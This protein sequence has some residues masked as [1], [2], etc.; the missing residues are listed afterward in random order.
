MSDE[1]FE[2]RSNVLGTPKTGVSS[3]LD[4]LAAY[5]NSLTSVGKSP[6]R[7]PDQTLTNDA[8][9]G[10]N[11][12]NSL[13]CADCHSGPAFTDS[14]TLIRHNVGTLT[15][16]SGQRL[17]TQLDGLDTPTLKGLWKSAPYLHDGSAE[18][19]RDVLTTRNPGDQH[20]NTSNLS[21]TQLNQLIA[22]LNQIDDLESA[23]PELRNPTVS[24]LSP[25]NRSIEVPLESNLVLKFNEFIQ[26]GTG[27]ITLKNLTDGSQTI[28]N[29]NDSSQV[30][31]AGAILTINPSA[32]LLH[33]KNYAVQISPTAIKDMTGNNYAGMI[34]DSTW[35]FTSAIEIPLITG[36]SIKS[37]DL[38]INPNMSPSNAIDG[39]GL[40]GDTPALEGS[41]GTHWSEQWW[42]NS[43]TG[44]ITIDLG[45]A[46]DLRTI[47]IWNYN[48]GAAI[49][50]GTR[51]AEIWVSPDDNEN[52]LVKLVTDGSGLHD[53][54]T[55]DFLLP[56]GTGLSDY[57]GFDLDLIGITNATLLKTAR[58]F[59]IKGISTWGLPNNG[60][61]Q[62]QFGGFP[63][64]GET[65]NAYE[66]W[67]SIMGLTPGTNDG[68]T[69]NADGGNSNNLLEFAFGGNPL[70]SNDDSKLTH[71]SSF[72]SDRDGNNE[73]VLTLLVRAGGT[74]NYNGPPA[75][76]TIDGIIYTI[77]GSAG[78]PTDKTI[79]I[80]EGDVPTNPA[81]PPAPAGYEY[82]SF[83]LQGS[84]DNGLQRGFFQGK[85]E[86]AQ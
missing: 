1:N 33:E 79:N 78:L 41:H 19:L 55:G 35:K 40:P 42:S 12:F 52:N 70:N 86:V 82:K 83:I 48:E 73:A 16:S 25:A 46:S 44:Q 71:L 64:T 31:F 14:A 37:G 29:I 20:G 81:L 50:R 66:N 6:H 24:A 56:E 69:Q 54:G 26:A 3:D 23:T 45:E 47:H 60:L 76:A 53:N 62:V 61:G 67:A 80:T 72:D 59:R 75:T 17:G 65:S 10:R 36:I 13:N 49:G 21:S 2:T 18:T 34:D 85:V 11:I 4:A 77:T 63:S 8:I 30:T 22:Y 57:P 5:I 84:V 58:L 38:G 7:N 39:T 32:D 9:A 51:N 15:S 27:V 68:F 43:R 28:I 74:W